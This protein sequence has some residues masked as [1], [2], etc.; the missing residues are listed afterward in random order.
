L[1]RLGWK[2]GELAIRRK[3]DPGKLAMAGRLRPETTL[4]IKRIAE[5]IHLGS[6]KSANA[7]LHLW[8]LSHA[9]AA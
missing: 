2:A 6:S 3:N 9:G 7:R 5:R 8:M 4:T 1:K